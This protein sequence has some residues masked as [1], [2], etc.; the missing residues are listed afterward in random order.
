ME[1]RKDSDQ[2]KQAAYMAPKAIKGRNKDAEAEKAN[3]DMMTRE[4]VWWPW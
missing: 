2:I 4:R 3:K 1:E